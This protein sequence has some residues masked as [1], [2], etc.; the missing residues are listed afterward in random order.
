MVKFVGFDMISLLIASSS[1]D[2]P[3]LLVFIAVL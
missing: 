3:C 2:G 1:S